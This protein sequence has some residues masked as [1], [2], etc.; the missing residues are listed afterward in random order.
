[1]VNIGDYPSASDWKR[2][3]RLKARDVAY[4][5]RAQKYARM[6]AS[7]DVVHFQQILNAYGSNVVFH[8][9]K[10]ATQA[11]RIIT[12]HELDNYQTEHPETNTIYNRADALIVHEHD[13]KDKL[14][15]LGV[16][17]EKIH[18]VFYGVELPAP[19][20]GRT[21]AGLVF[22]GGHKLMKGKGLDVLFGAVAQLR[23]RLGDQLPEVKI[24]GHYGAETPPEAG[25]LARQLGVENEIRWLNQLSHGEALS[26]YQSAQICLLPF[27]GGFAG[28]PAGLAA[29]SSLPVVATRKAGIPDYLGDCGVWIEPDNAEQL[30]DR[31]MQLLDSDELRTKLGVQL[32]RRAEQ[33]LGWDTIAKQTMEIYR[34]AGSH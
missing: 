6:S 31:V 26:L 29:S 23:Q 9:L 15:A 10:Q 13:L 19:D 28:Y 24:H 7:A 27:T 20:A 4:Y 1:M 5:F 14:I 11:T 34:L 16:R 32:R 2:N 8:W 18:V 22:Y 25:A 30:A 21:R 3:L 17:P 33:S 12:V